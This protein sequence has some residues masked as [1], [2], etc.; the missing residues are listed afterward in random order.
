[1]K[2][3]WTYA[4]HLPSVP[5]A[6][7]LY[8]GEGGTPLVKSRYIGN[9]IGLE[10]LYFKLENL[11][12]TGSY[13]DRFASVLVSQMQVAGQKVCIAT[14]SGNTGAALSAFC[15]AAGIRCVLVVVDGAPIPKIRQMQLYGAEILMV[16]DFG[17]SARVTGEVFTRLAEICQDHRLP[18][19]I[20]A[21]YYCPSAM[22]GVQTMV[23]EI[24]EQL[25]QAP[26]HIFRPRRWR[27]YA[28]YWP[29]SIVGK[30]GYQSAL[31]TARRQRY[32]CFS[33]TVGAG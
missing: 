6:S 14:S 9:A 26:D 23:Y 7:R 22:Q 5:K 33:L 31:C 24:M 32:H 17:K 29:G 21:F 10:H 2:T 1:M 30:G 16:K 12:P 25:P 11:N 19:P 4:E 13:K 15:A 18:L 28:G 8:L 20:S 3:I 27:P